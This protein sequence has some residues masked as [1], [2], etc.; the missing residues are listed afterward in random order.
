MIALG[1]GKF[2]AVFEPGG[3]PGDGWNGKTKIEVDG[4]GEGDKTTF[5]GQ[6]YTASFKGDGEA[7]AGKGPGG[8]FELKKVQRKSPTEG[9]KPPEGAVVLFDGTNTDAFPGGHMDERHLLGSGPTGK[10]KFTDYTLHVEFLLPFKPYGRGQGRANSGVYMQN[11]YEVQVL[12]SFGLKGQ[13]NECGGIYSNTAPTVNMCYPPLLWQTYDIDFTAARYDDAG[14]K[15]AEPS[16][17]SS[18]TA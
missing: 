14:K 13:N 2:H 12:D 5:D 18:T 11:R 16:S 9:A 3:L 6:D 1:G 10:Q 7:L 15:H 17:P 8:E 4:K